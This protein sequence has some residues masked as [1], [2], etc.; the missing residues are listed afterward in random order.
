MVL[1][2]ASLTQAEIVVEVCVSD[3]GQVSDAVIAEGGMAAIDATLRMAIRSWRYRPLLVN[4]APTPFCH[5]MK[6]K[7]ALN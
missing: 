4:G 3:R 6:L 5:F 7:Y 2:Q 1:A